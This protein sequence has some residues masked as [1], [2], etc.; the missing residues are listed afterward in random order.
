MGGVGAQF[1]PKSITRP[2]RARCPHR[3]SLGRTGPA[4]G[5]ARAAH[6]RRRESR[7]SREI[8][9]GDTHPS[10]AHRTCVR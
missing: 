3:P 1:I 5:R 10:L 2:V 4:R 6:G 7:R 9:A 8:S